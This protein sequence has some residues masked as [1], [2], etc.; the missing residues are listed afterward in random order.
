MEA[1]S[2]SVSM[3]AVFVIGDEAVQQI[4]DL[5]LDDVLVDYRNIIKLF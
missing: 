1:G 4:S 2:H 3:T 5:S